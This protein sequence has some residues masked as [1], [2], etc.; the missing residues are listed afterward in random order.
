M[1]E[2]RRGAGHL[3][4]PA[5]ASDGG[6]GQSDRDPALGCLFRAGAVMETGS[7]EPARALPTFAAR[8]WMR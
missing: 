5:V 8:P 1:A 2:L 3:E 6:D 7:R 4:A